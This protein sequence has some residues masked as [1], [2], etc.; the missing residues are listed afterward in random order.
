MLYKAIFPDR[1]RFISCSYAI[2]CQTE[3]KGC[4]HWTCLLMNVLWENIYSGFVYT[5]HELSNR[6]SAAPSLV[7]GGGVIPKEV[8]GNQVGIR[9]VPSG[10][11]YLMLAQV[12]RQP[13]HEAVWR[14]WMQN[15]LHHLLNTHL[16]MWP[17]K[18]HDYIIWLLQ[19]LVAA[20][21]Q[22]VCCAGHGTDKMGGQGLKHM[23]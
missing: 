19:L 15:K 4:T 13:C 10:C 22:I 23:F 20:V 5:N 2:L 3:S 16:P 7:G 21:S 8:L 11:T 17:L 6:Q 9:R 1:R 14:V 12:P 18:S